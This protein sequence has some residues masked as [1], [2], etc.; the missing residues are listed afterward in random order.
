M[1]T[2]Y[3]RVGVFLKKNLGLHGFRVFFLAEEVCVNPWEGESLHRRQNLNGA[4]W[5]L[6]KT[7]RRHY[8]NKD[9]LDVRRGPR[10][11]S[12]HRQML[13]GIFEMHNCCSTADA[14]PWFGEETDRSLYF[15][16]IIDLIATMQLF[17]N[18]KI[19][20][21][22]CFGVKKGM[23]ENR[24]SSISFVEIWNPLLPR[25]WT[26]IVECSKSTAK[27]KRSKKIEQLIHFKTYTSKPS[28]KSFTKNTHTTKTKHTMIKKNVP[29]KTQG[30][31][32]WAK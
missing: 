15:E 5:N 6:G 28:E 31:E 11:S 22:I 32:L 2:C 3:T 10:Q 20:V 14:A 8:I 1:T 13:A 19:F 16:I 7:L 17:F 30:L 18:G 9:T 12:A 21:G 4:C 25:V 27:T 23:P 26:L 29:W 24:V